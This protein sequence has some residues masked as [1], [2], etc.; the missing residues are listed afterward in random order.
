MNQYKA[1]YILSSIKLELDK[2]V[3]V[4]NNNFNNLELDGLLKNFTVFDVASVFEMS[5]PENPNSVLSVAH[6]IVT[7]GALTLASPFVENQMAEALCF[8][9]N[10]ES[11][12]IIEYDIEKNLDI[13]LVFRALHPID[14]RFKNRGGNLYNE[15]LDSNFEKDFLS[16]YIEKDKAHIS[17]MLQH[18]RKRNTLGA[19]ASNQG[20]VDF[21]LEIPYLNQQ[22]KTNKYKNPVN[23]K[24][25]K[26]YIIE[27]DGK[28]YHDQL[29]DD[30][31]DLEV[32]N[33]NTNIVHVTEDQ[34]FEDVESL[35]EELSSEK[36]VEIVKSNF[37][38]KIK[39]LTKIYSLIH[40]PIAIARIQKVVLLYLLNKPSVEKINLAVLERDVPCAELA[41]NDLLQILNNLCGITN[42]NIYDVP[43]IKL[44][45]FTSEE[46][47]NS[48]LHFGKSF[49]LIE[50]CNSK[51]YDVVI[52]IASLSKSNTVKYN[53]NVKGHNLIEIRNSHFENQK[54]INQV[55]SAESINYIDFVKP[56]GNELFEDIL[57]AK[58]K[59]EYFV[60]LIF[61]KNKFRVGQLPILNRALKNKSIIGLL[62]TG[63]G[64]S[65]TYQLAA[66]LQ[67]GIT[68]VVDPIRS[69]MQD[70]YD[71]LLKIGIDK[72][73]FINSSLEA[74]EKRY[75]QSVL[76][77]SGQ[78]Q[79]VFVSP[80]RFV[81]QDF[82]DLLSKVNEN[83]HF[84]SYA[85]ID[86]V[87][88]VSEWGHDFRT[89]YL[90]LGEN[91]IDHTKTKSNKSIPLFGLTATASFDVL[92][93]IERELKIPN[94]D[95]NAL[96]RYENS[97]RNEIN[98]QVIPVKFDVEFIKAS[99]NGLTRGEIGLKKQIEILKLLNNNN[100][101]ILNKFNNNDVLRTIL[102]KAYKDYLPESQKI[103]GEAFEY[104]EDYIKTQT[105]LL[106]LNKEKDF[107]KTRDEKHK[108]GTVVFCPH[109]KGALGVYGVKSHISDEKEFDIGYFVGSGDD[110]DKKI[111]DKESFENLK[112]FQENEQNVMIAT[113]AFGM[114][115]D[116]A[117]VRK[118]IH[119]NPPSSIE[120]FVQEAGRAGRDQ[121]LSLSSIL[122]STKEV[123]ITE[124]GKIKIETQF[125][126]DDKEV[127]S[128]FHNNSFK[129]KLKE[130]QTIYELRNK[131]H[132]PNTNKFI[133]LQYEV[134]LK[135][136]SFPIKFNWTKERDGF[137]INTLNTND[138]IGMI[139]LSRWR[140][141]PNKKDSTHHSI[142][143]EIGNYVLD[144]IKRL[145]IKSV[146]LYN[147]LIKNVVN[148]QESTGIENAFKAMSLDE[149]K[150]IRIPFT[151]KYYPPFKTEEF[152]GNKID[153]LNPNCLALF[154]N[155]ED[156][157]EKI[158]PSDKTKASNKNFN[159]FLIKHFKN[160][161][162]K[163]LCDALHISDNDLINKT[164]RNFL[165]PRSE[166]DT[167]KAI[168]RMI[169]VG[170]IDDYTIDYA[171]KLYK[172]RIVKKEKEFYFNNLSDLLTRYVSDV[173]ADSEVKKLKNKHKD[174]IEAGQETVIGVCVKYLTDFVYDKIAE[175]RRQ[176]IDDMISMCKFALTEKDVIVQTNIIKD[177]IYYYFNAKYSRRQNTADVII[178]K[179]GE[180][181][182]DK[183]SASLV[184]DKD[185][186]ISS[187][188]TIIKYLD[189]MENDVSAS[190]KN[191][192]KHLRGACM[193]ML[194][195]YPGSPTYKILKSYTLFILSETTPA[196]LDEAANELYSGITD[197][198]QEAPQEKLESTLIKIR[199]ELLKQTN[200]NKIIEAFEETIAAVKLEYYS[201]WTKK[202]TE[203]FT[204]K[205]QIL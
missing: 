78:L 125:G 22:I 129:G 141:H 96:V 189:L 194:R 101:L 89:P 10:K 172:I 37:N 4:D 149:L 139:S 66:M 15:D 151:N 65:L 117:N 119:I 42:S 127:L 191:N 17:F 120:S 182:R 104:I 74:G 94:N 124:N 103:K 79:F 188:D 45:I 145:S 8:T 183:K 115:I 155:Y 196:L 87:H 147:F 190:F 29:I 44:T 203:K 170:I 93:D 143:L 53:H 1:G 154:K 52:D 92:A 60:Q 166:E 162:A 99:Q 110:L 48:P 56:L 160:G 84:F 200:N 21:S 83:N 100:N 86:E 163:S 57:E 6:N 174:T 73:A 138:Y 46:F 144:K 26:A 91:I 2:F 181:I 51:L 202:F 24:N 28:K 193:R 122:V 146:N 123:E 167:A 169:S 41:I 192:I 114:G 111:I 157:Y 68:I 18:Q 201:N 30:L 132:F 109:K 177:E 5:T 77:P 11:K 33:F 95:G 197:W 88:C 59:L 72:A 142:T 58:E 198:T 70:Q 108:D 159:N 47:K 161:T 107:G 185:Q 50:N 180:E 76:F 150:E 204:E 118:T 9:K 63:G 49:D 205:L 82:R 34:V 165:T 130:R 158:Y 71:G 140:V 128:W 178:I 121:K 7:R 148:D 90:S 173:Y 98:Y 131:I 80:E 164:T 137:F 64:K 133:Q 199:G 105:S 97:I 69:L 40:T 168:Y 38:S 27:I 13:N 25:N 20:R 32:N 19:G 67:P 195:V 176:A 156:I 31:K 81:I 39:D 179:D 23:V 175:K 134:N 171:N 55:I 106:L 135:F 136:S 112:F 43:E 62:P 116:K 12:D 61:R 85:V 54:T 35:I 16:K 3:K 153:V 152:E 102:E 126:E 113:K 14:S 36:Y 184:F 186:E 187:Y 75:N